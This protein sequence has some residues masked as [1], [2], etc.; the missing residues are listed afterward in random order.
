[1]DWCFFFAFQFCRNRGNALVTF[2]WISLAGFAYAIYG[3][4]IFWGDYGTLFWFLIIT[5][6]GMSGARL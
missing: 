4:I 3:L 5:S 2:K 1:M 6:K